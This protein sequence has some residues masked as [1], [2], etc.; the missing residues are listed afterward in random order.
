MAYTV[1]QT[2]ACDKKSSL[3]NVKH[4]YNQFVLN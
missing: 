4:I 3:L 1:I 2:H